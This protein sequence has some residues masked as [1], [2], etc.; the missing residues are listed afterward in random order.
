M[1]SEELKISVHH[2]NRNYTF[3]VK[4]WVRWTQMAY[5]KTMQTYV[6]EQPAVSYR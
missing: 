1:H 6:R 5:H 4:T 3:Y 2:I